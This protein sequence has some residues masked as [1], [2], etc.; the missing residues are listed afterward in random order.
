MRGVFAYASRFNQELNAWN[1]SKVTNMRGMFA[2]ASRFNQELNAWNVSSVT[3]MYGMFWSASS[4]NQDLCP[5]GNIPTFPYE[6]VYSM[7]FRSSCTY[8]DDPERTNKGPF[9]ASDC[10]ASSLSPSSSQRPSSRDDDSWDNDNWDDDN[11]DGDN[12]GGDNLY[13]NESHQVSVQ[14]TATD[15]LAGVST[16][17]SS[18]STTT[19]TK[20]PKQIC[21][22][23]GNKK[24]PKIPQKS[25][26]TSCSCK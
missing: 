17:S 20:P 25:T 22:Y 1:V 14:A 15:A 11:W 6:S 10:I 21:Y 8:P 26:A 19:T 7:F 18:S 9:C 16:S 2:Y 5:W 13:S 3:D 23:P 24:C 12:W 4:F